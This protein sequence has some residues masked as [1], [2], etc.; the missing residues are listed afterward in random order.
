MEGT[1]EGKEE[2]NTDCIEEYS[3]EEEE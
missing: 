1:E 2:A 3:D